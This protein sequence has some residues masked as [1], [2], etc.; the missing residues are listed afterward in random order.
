MSLLCGAVVAVGDV[1]C[2]ILFH[3]THMN[4]IDKIIVSGF[5]DVGA[6]NGTVCG[7]GAYNA[8]YPY[9][10]YTMGNNP[11][12]GL[13]YIKWNRGFGAV[14]VSVGV[15]VP[16]EFTRGQSRLR[17]SGRGSQGSQNS[18][19]VCGGSFLPTQVAPDGTVVGRHR[20]IVYWFDKLKYLC[21]LGIAIF[22][23]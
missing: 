1:K 23:E 3:A 6:S 2:S 18:Q 5:Q 10:D 20:E 15:V 11:T 21:P 9:V 16:S 12:S 7:I 19:A 4:A 13:T 14:I 8:M 17:N 22:K